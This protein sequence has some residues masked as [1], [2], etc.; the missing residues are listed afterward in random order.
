[1]GTFN[2]DPRRG[3]GRREGLRA[4]LDHPL[5][6]DPEPARETGET[7]T[8]DWAEDGPGR[9]RVD[10]ILPSRTLTVTGSGILWPGETPVL[11]VTGETAAV[12]SDHRLIWVDLAF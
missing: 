2:I 1:M 3:E 11:G 10:Y 12:A 5:L 4:L 7:A 6:Q 8:A 9:L